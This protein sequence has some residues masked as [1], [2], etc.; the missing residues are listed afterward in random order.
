MAWTDASNAYGS[1]TNVCP[2]LGARRELCGG[3]IRGRRKRRPTR[4]YGHLVPSVDR[5]LADGLGVLFSAGEAAEQADVVALPVTPR[6]G[7]L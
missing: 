6:G 1:R 5:A 2:S 7:A 4:A 3:A